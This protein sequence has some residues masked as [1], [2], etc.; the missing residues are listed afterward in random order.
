MEG[1]AEQEGKVG[2]R[3]FEAVAGAE[4]TALIRQSRHSSIRGGSAPP[5]PE[6]FTCAHI[7]E[8]LLSRCCSLLPRGGDGILGRRRSEAGT[9]HVCTTASQPR[10]LAGLLLDDCAR[11]VFR[12]LHLGEPRQHVARRVV[13]EIR[14]EFPL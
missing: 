6:M 12:H 9:C 1:R 13:V 7:G 10:L 5:T 3:A 2:R 8:A 14:R 4:P 11:P